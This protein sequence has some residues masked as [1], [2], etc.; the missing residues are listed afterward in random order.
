[1]KTQFSIIIYFDPFGD[2]KSNRKVLTKRNFESDK[3]IHEIHEIIEKYNNGKYYNAVSIG[4]FDKRIKSISNFD[5]SIYINSKARPSEF[6][7]IPNC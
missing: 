5:N 7:N 6:E 3:P 1:M 4:G 2:M